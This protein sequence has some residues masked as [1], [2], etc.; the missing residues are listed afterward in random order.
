MTSQRQQHLG[1]Y[2]ESSPRVHLVSQP[3]PHLQ[4]QVGTARIAFE[5]YYRNT[6]RKFQQVKDC[7]IGTELQTPASHLQIHVGT[8][9]T[10]SG[11]FFRDTSRKFQQVKDRW[12]GTDI[13]KPA[14][15]LQIQ[16][17]TARIPFENYFH[18]TSRKFQQ[19]R[20]RWIGTE[21]KIEG[22]LL[23]I[24]LQDEPLTPAIFYVGV[25]TLAGSIVS[26]NRSLF[27]R[28][29][30]PPVFLATTATLLLPRTTDNVRNCAWSIEQQHSPALARHH[31]EIYNKAQDAFYKLRGS[32]QTLRKHLTE[33]VSKGAHRLEDITGLKTRHVFGSIRVPVKGSGP[34][35][36][37]PSDD[38]EK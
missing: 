10:A 32:T 29:I 28:L 7:W 33:G 15:Y 13:Q 26:R 11:F 20:D 2:D 37:S 14:S 19:V 4:I 9:R 27:S 5:N 36:N 21:R 35:N 17:G 25:A 34:P 3:A 31:A 6:R 12:I 24:L 23:N 18:N 30:L 38:V 22:Q 16:I 1:I 8:A